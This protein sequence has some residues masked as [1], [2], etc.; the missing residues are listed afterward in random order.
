M[1]FYDIETDK[2]F[3][4]ELRISAVDFLIHCFNKLID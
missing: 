2:N 1:D 4:E 3:K